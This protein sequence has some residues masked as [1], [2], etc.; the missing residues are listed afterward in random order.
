MPIILR[1]LLVLVG[2]VVIVIG[3]NVGLGGIHT[4]GWQYP[5]GFAS[6]TI[7]EVFTKQDSHVRY[8][9]G[10]FVAGGGVFIASAAFP[11]LA[12]AALTVC[13]MAFI[14]GLFRLVDMDAALFSNMEIMR[15]LIA[16]LLLFPAIGYWLW[17]KIKQ[18]ES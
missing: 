13:V 2:L 18:P 12:P 5:P 15:S 11:I 9:G 8:L 10:V 16:E 17:R 3:L 14:G 1:A 7:P 6:E 4:L